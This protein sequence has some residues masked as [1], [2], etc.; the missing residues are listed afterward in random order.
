[1][2]RTW[3][4]IKDLPG[5]FR[6]RGI[7][8]MIPNE[9]L[10]RYA[11]GGSL[12]LVLWSTQDLSGAIHGETRICW[13]RETYPYGAAEPTMGK[14]LGDIYL[15][16]YKKDPERVYPP[17]EDLLVFAVLE[18]KQSGYFDEPSMVWIR[19]HKSM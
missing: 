12:A 8:G 3:N 2:I 13:L 5:N 9:V 15:G 18:R 1:M 4:R 7:P 6:L 19:D 17:S 10:E 11:K 16:T 14:A